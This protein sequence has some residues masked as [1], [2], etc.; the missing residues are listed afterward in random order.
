MSLL[1]NKQVYSLIMK[2]PFNDL[3]RI[4]EPLR[5]KF[6]EILDGVLDNSSARWLPTKPKPPVIIIFITFYNWTI[7]LTFSKLK[8]YQIKLI[9]DI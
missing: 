4:H 8:F 6:H 9:R 3:K 1:K 7:L 5:S 2:V